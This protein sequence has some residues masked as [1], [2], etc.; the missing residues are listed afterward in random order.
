MLL[1]QIKFTR[2]AKD[3]QF[4][5]SDEKPSTATSEVSLQLKWAMTISLIA[6][7][8][9]KHDQQTQYKWKITTENLYSHNLKL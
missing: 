7:S 5:V 9:F 4:Q 6:E 1:L 2:L 8:E 3:L